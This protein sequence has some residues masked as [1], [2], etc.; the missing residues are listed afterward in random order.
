MHSL[1]IFNSWT[2]FLSLHLQNWEKT[3]E[4]ASSRLVQRGGYT[5]QLFFCK[6]QKFVIKIRPPLSQLLSILAQWLQII[7]SNVPSSYHKIT[8]KSCWKWI[9]SSY[10]SPN[11]RRGISP[12]LFSKKYLNL[13]YCLPEW[14]FYDGEIMISISL[15]FAD[16]PAQNMECSSKGNRKQHIIMRLSPR[17]RISPKT[18]LHK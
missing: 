8:E 3:C 9:S 18:E 2:T 1:Q 10:I 11:S 15:S 12:P 17:L 13:W 16:Q 5:A 6:L 4:A 7:N 14:I